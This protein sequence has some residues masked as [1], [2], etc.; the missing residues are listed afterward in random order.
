MEPAYDLIAL[1]I[2]KQNDQRT[3]DFG[4]ADTAV[5]ERNQRLNDRLPHLRCRRIRKHD[6]WNHECTPSASSFIAAYTIQA[7]IVPWRMSRHIVRRGRHPCDGFL[8]FQSRTFGRAG[9]P[10]R[11]RHRRSIRAASG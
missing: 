2:G 1:W 4:P 11:Y 7:V 8:P 9:S 10:A 3:I 6:L 5:V